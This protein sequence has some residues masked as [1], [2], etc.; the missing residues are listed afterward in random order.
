MRDN[1]RKVDSAISMKYKVKKPNK[2]LPIKFDGYRFAEK[3]E[4][5]LLAFHTNASKFSC[6]QQLSFRDKYMKNENLNLW[7]S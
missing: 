7:L 2:R 6:K 4:I 5:I 3:Q 1:L